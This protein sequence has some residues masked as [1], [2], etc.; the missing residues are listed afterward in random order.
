M[1]QRINKTICRALFYSAVLAV[2]VLA[3]AI[4]YEWYFDTRIDNGAQYYDDIAGVHKKNNYRSRG[5]K[6]PLS[7]KQGYWVYWRPG[8]PH[9]TEVVEW[10]G[11][12]KSRKLVTY[13]GQGQKLKEGVYKNDKMHGFWVF[14]TKT[15]QVDRKLTG[16]YA[17]NK[18]LRN[19]RNEF[20]PLP[21]ADHPFDYIHAT[22]QLVIWISLICIISLLI[23]LWVFSGV[24][25][26][27]A[28]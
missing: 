26:R 18:L 5:R 21:S 12:L 1:G 27:K 6:D 14:W 15:M 2:I 10:F 4:V 20:F 24:S 19:A 28:K 3:S 7:G 8:P 16:L 9:K 17:N 25:K 22:I 23:I 13:P 11:N